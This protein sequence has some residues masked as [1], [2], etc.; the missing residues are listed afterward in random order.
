MRNILLKAFA[1]F[2][3]VYLLALTTAHAKTGE[4]HIRWSSQSGEVYLDGEARSVIEFEGSKVEDSKSLL[5]LYRAQFENEIVA[6]YGITEPVFAPLND[7]EAAHVNKSDLGAEI[8]PRVEVQY[9]RGQPISFVSF[10][11]LMV[12]PVTNRVEKLV[13]FK[14]TYIPGQ[15][16]SSGINAH[17][18]NYA[19][20]S[21]LAQGDWIKM[22]VSKD[23]VHRV[24]YD[25][26][27]QR[28]GGY[29]G[30]PVAEIRVFGN[31]GG[32][33]PQKNDDPRIDDLK[34]NPIMVKDING[35]GAFDQGDYIVFYA[36]GPHEWIL[37]EKGHYLQQQNI[38]SDTS[39]YFITH[40]PQVQGLRIQSQTAPT[41]N[42]QSDFHYFDN[43]LQHEQDLNNL[44]Q[45]G[46][47][48]YGEIFDFTLNRN[49]QFDLGE[50]D[51]S[52]TIW[53]RVDFA[54]IS[55]SGR[56]EFT[57]TVNGLNF[58]S[59]ILDRTAVPYGDY[60]KSG[61]V[62]GFIDPSTL[63]NGMLNVR[64]SFN[65]N[66]NGAAEG[67]LNRIRVHSV[68]KT[69]VPERQM[70]FRRIESQTGGVFEYHVQQA[71]QNMMVWEVTNPVAPLSQSTSF[72][73]GELTFKHQNAN[74]VVPEFVV[75]DP[76]FAYAPV[77]MKRIANQNLHQHQPVD[78]VIFSP[79][80]FREE[81]QRLADFRWQNDGIQSIVVN[82]RLVY[83]EFSSGAQDLSAL[84][85]YL[86]ML[87]DRDQ[88]GVLKYVMLFGD[89]S[90]DYKDRVFGNTNFVPCY[91]S[92]QSH[93][94]ID[95][96]S[97]D[98]YFAFLEDGK[99]EWKENNTVT[100]MDIGVGRLPVSTIEE[101]SVMVDKIIH[102]SDQGK[103]I[104]DWRTWIS[105]VAD[106]GDGNT[107]QADADGLA[108]KVANEHPEYN[109]NKIYLGSYDQ[110]PSP[111]G[112]VSPAAKEAVSRAVEEGSLI[113]NYSGHGGPIGWT[114]EQI[115]RT[116][117]IEDW[118]NID[119]LS[120]FFT[121]TCEFGRYDDP[122]EVAGGEL[123]LLNPNG[124]AIGLMTT[125]RPVWSFSNYNLNIE[126]YN[127]A[128]K[129]EN[130]DYLRLGE[131]IRR[132][133]NAYGINNTRNFA[134]LGD[135]SMKLN[136]P[137]ERIK[138]THVNKKPV[139][140]GSD[141][142][143]ALCLV[144]VDGEIQGGDSMLL[145]S[146]DGMADGKFFDKPLQIQT[147][148]DNGRIFSYELYRNYIYKGFASVKDGRFSF[149]FIVPKDID[150]EIGKGRVNIYASSSDNS[151]DASGS[152]EDVYVG[153]SCDNVVLDDEPPKIQLFLDDT[154][155]VNG[156]MV[157]QDPLLIAFL[158]DESGINITGT[159]I[160]RGLSSETS[161]LPGEKIPMNDYYQG[162]PDTYKRGE[163]NYPFYGFRE[164]NHTLT[165]KAWDTHNNSSAETIS[166]I[167][168]GDE[169]IALSYL[170]NY[171]NPFIERTFI[172]FDH[173]R[174]GDD[175]D[176]ELEIM[177]SNGQLIQ[178]RK[179]TIQES[180]SI[181]SGEAYPD[182]T[183]APSEGANRP[184][185][186]GVF[187]FRLKVI[188]RED[189]T[190]FKDVKRMVFIQ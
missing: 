18:Y 158:E 38:Y 6:W 96:Y 20:N 85:N 157:S 113:L 161:A 163:V 122:E 4:V 74:G 93:N 3:F 24:T 23:G 115:L 100:I 159:G 80:R 31:G 105:F 70:S 94:N 162:Y 84:R 61:R 148:E 136:Y 119:Q 151:I 15:S 99:G 87:Y 167:V 65:K 1:G 29:A 149:E 22:G 64:V 111:A 101:A 185:S 118:T 54:H 130:N 180:P 7:W 95:S 188:S 36:G 160:G 155:F 124:G 34:E 126:F 178:K 47:E 69:K 154:S 137:Q 144:S 77:S 140:A 45:S 48:W 116:E 86:K 152:F 170:Y 35:N 44:I 141:T 56:T 60:A 184:V 53:L 112:A 10:V 132:T 179:L 52:S 28:D 71:N 174:A 142:L 57:I 135:P 125:T 123:S 62:E 66:G 32:M 25:Q 97:S 109:I 120:F 8:R 177:G 37:Q 181:V 165:F 150:Y 12:N 103:T 186:G 91:Q 30:I 190:E 183:W 14:Y 164:G 176:I 83:N 49:Y 166:F 173:N 75:F 9:S 82:P 134:L 42:A 107:H 19:P 27:V 114:E 102:Y 67:Y 117:Q 16:H 156:A 2:S 92:Y 110:V 182:L 172:G 168:A 11:P 143:N 17:L 147:L 40:T 138:I 129:K 153:G 139:S 106:D 59:K 90:Y 128:F 171:P 68:S 5:P 175:L 13:S 63:T 189:G 72:N 121:A 41:G 73:A 131:I 187:F 43:R 55:V 39:F 133:K 145:A 108:K 21:V 26:L 76:A 169:K 46:R 79:N 33:L 89:C 50:V 78:M 81:A 58:G 51:L 104:G 146:F 88:S 127:R 98:D